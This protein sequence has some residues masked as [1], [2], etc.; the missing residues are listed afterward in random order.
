MSESSLSILLVDDEELILVSLKRLLELSGYDVDTAYNGRD[1]INKIHQSKFHVIISDIEMPQMDGLELLTRI[2][3]NI[4]YS[5]PVILMTGFLNAEYAIEAIRRGAS[6]FIRKPIDIKQLIKSVNNLLTGS[7]IKQQIQNM[8]HQLSSIDVEFH[9][10]PRNFLETDISNTLTVMFQQYLSLNTYFVNEIVLC[11]EEML[12]NAFIH[13]TLNL[14]EETRQMDHFNYKTY[15]QKAISDDDIASKKIILR[16]KLNR[17]DRYLQ[18][19]VSDQGNG[20]NYHHWLERTRE[21]L[22]SNLTYHGRG[23]GLIKLLV[24]EIQFQDDGRTIIVRK[25]LDYAAQNISEL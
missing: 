25:N 14:Q 2:R 9:F 15:V 3:K 10:S 5:L 6:D 24:D 19:T 7:N 20:F 16:V 12:N 21:D 13:G 8:A 22:Q 17:S 11:L 4:D 23:I 18:L 1:A